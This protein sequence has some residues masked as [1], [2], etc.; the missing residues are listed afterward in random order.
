MEANLD[1]TFIH[2]NK[3]KV[4]LYGTLCTTYPSIILINILVYNNHIYP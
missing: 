2:L 3:L 4:V 1:L